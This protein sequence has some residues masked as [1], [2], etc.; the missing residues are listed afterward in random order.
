MGIGPF[1]KEMREEFN[2]K[3]FQNELAKQINERIEKIA[4]LNGV[5]E[6]LLIADAFTC[7]VTEID[8]KPVIGDRLVVRKEIKNEIRKTIKKLEKIRKGKND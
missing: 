5:I 8:G 2:F 7:F 1:I 4:Y 6:G 3:K